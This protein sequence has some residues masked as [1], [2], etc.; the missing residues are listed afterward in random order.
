VTSVGPDLGRV[1]LDH[2]PLAF[3][4]LGE[5]TVVVLLHQTPRSWD[6]YRDVLPLLAARGFQALALDTPGFGDSAPVPGTASIQS[7]ASAMQQALDSLGVER[8]VVVGHHT[9]GAIATELAF[10]RPDGVA[11]LVLSSTALTDAEFRSRPSDD[12]DVDVGEDAESLRR[13][14]AGFYPADR[15]GLLDRYVADALRA[16]PLA[17]LGHHVVGA[18]QMDDKPTRL[19]MPVL[20]IGADRDPYAYPQL[21]RFQRVL[22][23]ARTAVIAEGMVPLPDGWPTEFA[24]LVGDFAARVEQPAR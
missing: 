19:T 3:A 24:R 6:E 7:W 8:P 18:Y 22:P 13:S 14:R 5:G 12:S 9:G 16:G 15:P 20:L 4:R 17:R 21:A 1:E 2:G 23:H 10:Q 11:G